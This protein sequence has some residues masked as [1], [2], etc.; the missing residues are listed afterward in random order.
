[1]TTLDPET[2]ADLLQ[3]IRRFVTE[4][5]IPVEE[6]VDREDRIPDDIVAEMRALGLYGVT[7]PQEYG[8]LGLSAEES[9]LVFFEL[10]RAAPAFR[11][12]IGINNGLGSSTILADGNDAQRAKY[13]ARL[14]SGE[15]IA[16]FCLTEPDSGSDAGALRTTARRD[17]DSYVLDGTKR[18]ITNAP[19]AGI[20]IVMA[21]TDESKAGAAGV[22][23][24][25]VEAGTPGL[26]VGR[27]DRKMGQKGAHLADVI[28]EGCRIPATAMLGREGQGF[29]VAMRALDRGRIHIAAM[30]VGLAE[31]LIDEGLGYALERPQFGKP[32]A[33]YQLV[34]AM[35]ADSK[36][37]AYAA[38][39]MV[40]DTAKR[41][42][43]GE[44]ISTE[45]SCCKMFASEM[46]GRVADR[47]VQIHGG[48]GYISECAAERLYRDVRV[49]RLYEGTTQI[50]Q[51]IIA[52][53]MIRAAREAAA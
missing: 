36:T 25:V 34:Q 24:F 41:L 17:G 3:T 27:N 6:R 38:R 26:S 46:V 8:G 2:L 9:V 16:A 29:K 49:F 32:I 50:Q 12:V 35:L 45:A 11:S 43:R 20:F 42:D 30:C 18:F 5:L 47:T 10:C 31:R 23:A 33:E 22:S 40:L 1:M 21:R 39:C 13:V 19:E 37:E 7:I 15:L 44:R 51:L 48:A 28:M 4:R 14:A 53:D 52:R